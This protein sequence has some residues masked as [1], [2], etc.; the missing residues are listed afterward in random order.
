MLEQEIASAMKF[1]IGN[2]GNPAPYY[3]EV[4]QD[5]VVPAVYFPQPE[6]ESRGDT[7]ATYA[8]EYTWFVKFFHK[9]TQ[10]AFA[11]GFDVLT[12]LK[13]FKNIIPRID[14]TGKLTGRSFRMRDPA[15]KPID[16]GA[17]QLTLM[18]DSAR[19][20]FEQKSQKMMKFKAFMYI[21]SAFDG[22]VTQLKNGG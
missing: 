22:A 8:L 10:S 5:F 15:L 1:I 9:D 6:I 2:S 7:L 16:S 19:P 14:E 4:P 21:K 17:V 11:L 13:Y 12:A 3:Y 20:Y 18:W